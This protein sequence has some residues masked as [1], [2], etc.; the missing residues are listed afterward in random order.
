MRQVACVGLSVGEIEEDRG[1]GGAGGADRQ[2]GGAGGA[3]R[4]ARPNRRGG[5]DAF[6]PSTHKQR[7]HPL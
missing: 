4:S 7:P 1:A 5:G 6:S 3:G 2:A